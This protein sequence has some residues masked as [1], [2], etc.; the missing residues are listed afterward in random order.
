MLNLLKIAIT[1]GIASGKSTV[2]QFFKE[3]GAFVV[4]ADAI[5]HE[6]LT[7][8]TDLGK[9]A[10]QLLG[11][12]VPFDRGLFR[13]IIAEK[14][15]KDPNRLAK[16]EKILH[17]EVLKK[18]KELYIQAQEK[19]TYTNFIVEI[20]LLF[21]IQNEEFYDLVITVLS[22]EEIARKRFEQ[23]GFEPQEYEQRM[24]RQMNPSKKAL[25]SDYVIENN[26][27]LEELKN[28]VILINQTLERV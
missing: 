2:C 15:F 22:R 17:P 28:K 19:G 21:E 10:I 27:S 26:G 6:L 3:L 7:P 1:G 18:I 5:V 24:K 8:D 4:N 12:Q 9:Q 23:S 16:L 11:I 13:K 14:V 25:L 20:P